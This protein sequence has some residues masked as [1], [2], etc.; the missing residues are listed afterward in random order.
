[1]GILENFRVDGKVALVTGA[2]RGIG[3]ASALALAEAGA[4]VVVVHHQAA[5]HG[6]WPWF[7]AVHAKSLPAQAFQT[8]SALCLTR[9]KAHTRPMHKASRLCLPRH[10]TKHT[11]ATPRP[12]QH[13][14]WSY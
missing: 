1:M 6:G 3:K 2:G 12:T 7:S 5:V 9:H 10:R 8:V 13:R 4:D 11:A 14:P